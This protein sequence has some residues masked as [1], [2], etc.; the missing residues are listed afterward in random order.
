MPFD[1]ERPMRFT[2]FRL[3]LRGLMVAVAIIGLL[4]GGGVTLQ[5]RSLRFKRLADKHQAAC[6][7]YSEMTILNWVQPGVRSDDF[8]I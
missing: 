6:S 5:R 8:L 7:K 2:R 3:H 4:L 1:T